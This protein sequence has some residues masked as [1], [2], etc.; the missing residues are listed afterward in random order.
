ML[1]PCLPDVPW[2]GCSVSPQDDKSP[3]PASLDAGWCY[4]Q[5]DNWTLFEQLMAN[6]GTVGA[7]FVAEIQ[8]P[9]SYVDALTRRVQLQDW[10][11]GGDAATL[12]SSGSDLTSVEQAEPETLVVDSKATHVNTALVASVSPTR[13]P[14]TPPYVQIA[15]TTACRALPC[16]GHPLK[17]G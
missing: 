11:A 6:A 5:E 17:P 4:P 10:A 12:G 9:R 7:D 8:R 14:R 2:P 3:V 13:D 16:V 1:V 15:R